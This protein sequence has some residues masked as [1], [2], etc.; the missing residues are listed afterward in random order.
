MASSVKNY[1]YNSLYS[2]LNMLLPLATAPYLARVLGKTGVGLYAYSFSVVQYFVLIAK[3]GLVNYGTR[4][5]AKVRDNNKELSQMF[6]TLF[7]M[8]CI[9]TVILTIAYI[10]Y[11]HF[12]AGQHKTVAAIFLIWLMGSFLD[13]DWF[14]FALEQ[15]KKTAI[16]NIF[17][18][19]ITVFC[20]LI[21][22]KSI[23]DVPLYAFI[24]AASYVIGY[25]TIWIG[26]GK[27]VHFSRP[28]LSRMKQYILPC[29]I[30]LIPVLAL[31]V[32]RSMD[33]VMLGAMI[34]MAETGIYDNGEKLIYCLVGFITS[35]GTVMLPKMSYLIEKGDIEQSKKYTSISLRFIIF[36]TSGMTFGLIG[37]SKSI[38]LVLF[39]NEFLKSA[40]ILSLCAP[41]LI[42]IGWSNVIRTQYVIPRK[43]DDIYIKSILFGAIVNLC[44]NVL[45][46]PG[47]QSTG[48]VIGTL[49]AEFFVPF[50]QYLRLHKEID[51]KKNAAVS[52]PYV[53]IGCIMAAILKGLDRMMGT[54]FMTLIVQ[55]ISGGLIYIACS[56]IYLS[57]FDREMMGFLKNMLR[58][59]RFSA[60]AR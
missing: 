10:N 22:V 17:V 3:L 40:Q 39:G 36:M 21:F 57:K 30:M 33:K 43:R 29:V 60:E 9:A 41:T 46:I 55:V 49:C 15:F 24:M 13:I 26:I 37:V 32:Y 16:R 58:L 8:Q 45:L 48:A 18:R 19:L 47:F 56:L 52:L 4:E 53:F 2:V 54:S 11:I 44:I 28:S 51:Y 27:S 6:S 7:C 35:L 42:F 12:F 1:I 50:Y 59:K 23:E 31:N 34:D 38:V 20:I 5:I 25:A 14:W